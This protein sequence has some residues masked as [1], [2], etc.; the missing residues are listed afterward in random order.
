MK[1]FLSIAAAFAMIFGAA[2]CQREPVPGQKGDCK[3]SFNVVIP[4][5]VVT[6][7]QISDGSTVDELLYEVYVGGEEMYYGSVQPTAPG[8]RQFVLELDLV[9]N[10]TYDILFWAQKK[11]AGHYKTSDLRRISTSY[12]TAANDETRDAFYGSVTGFTATGIATERTVT[13]KRPFAQ[14]NFGSS[15]N[16]WAKAGPFI[17]ESGLKS[18]VIFEGA[19]IGFNVA[20]G[21]VLPATSN[22]SFTLA[23]APASEHMDGKDDYTASDYLTYNRSSYGWIGMNYIFAPKNE[24]ALNKV[25]GYFVH[26]KNNED[27]ALKKVVYNVPFKQNYRTNILGEIFTGGN[28]FTVV[29]EPAFDNNPI[30]NYPDY[31]IAEPLMF[32]FENGGSITLGDN[33]VIPSPLILDGNKELIL[34][35]NG[36]SITPA[37]DMWNTA[38]GIWSMISVRNGA[39]LTI[40]G[41]TRSSIVAKE[42]DSYV[43]DVRGGATVT[44]NSGNYV[45]NISAVYVEEGT[46]NINGG[47]FSIQQLSEPAN[48]GDERF[49]LNC[50]DASYTAGTAAINVTGGSFVNFNPA[51]NLA[52]GAGTN[53]VTAGTVSSTTDSNGKV[54]YTV[55]Q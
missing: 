50:K 33:V 44:I 48:G 15:P 52:E 55:A 32:A 21:D 31:T 43:I 54:T 5:D 26:D 39:K 6:K 13:L 40:N 42:N 41:N 16:D 49:T 25:I 8:S 47:H 14:I 12:G 38:D 19:H 7:A 36:K 24:G 2:S 27:I 30:E 29:I 4:E 11:G 20:T 17:R 23:L 10:M 35:L 28:K 34:N 46:A 37:R 22:A 45:G 53:F 51:N 3:V 18:K 1:R 9:T